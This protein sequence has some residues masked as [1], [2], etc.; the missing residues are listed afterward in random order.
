VTARGLRPGD[1]ND[2]TYKEVNRGWV[3]IGFYWD[4]LEMIWLINGNPVVRD[5]KLMPNDARMYML[6]TREISDVIS[7]YGKLSIGILRYP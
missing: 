6:L 5:T 3:R 1:L 4:D 7:E 2:I